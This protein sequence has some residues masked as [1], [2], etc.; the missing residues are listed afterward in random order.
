MNKMNVLILGGNGMLGP[1]VVKA[2][3]KEHVLR[4]TDINDMEDTP[5]EYRKIDVSDPDQ[6]I[7]AAEG[8]DAIVNLSVLRED[9]RL[10]FDVNARGCYNMMAAAVHH[11][12]RRVVNTGPPFMYGPSYALFDYQLGPDLPPQSGTRL[13]PFTKALGQEI[14]QVFTEI[15]DIYVMTF[16]FGSF[17]DPEDPS[18][19]GKGN[20]PFIQT[21]PEAA[22]AIALALSVDLDGLPSRCELF[23]VCPD[24]PGEKYTNE[25]TKRILGW[26]PNDKFEKHWTKSG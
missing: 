15:H 6:V 19:F 11:G 8:M 17:R 21:F 13:Y 10:A 7:A 14:C 3:G 18:G 5:Y 20:L 9:R 23:N 25:K 26:R 4:L 12:I 16:M 2:V 24:F 1:Y 22:E